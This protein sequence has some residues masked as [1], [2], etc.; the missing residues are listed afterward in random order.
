MAMSQRSRK[1]SRPAELPIVLHD[2]EAAMTD[3][4]ASLIES[5]LTD[6]SPAKRYYM[7]PLVQQASLLRAL[8]FEML[9]RRCVA[10]IA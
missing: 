4:T 1:R 5:S 7:A 8:H 10:A 2:H 9:S 6:S 3:L